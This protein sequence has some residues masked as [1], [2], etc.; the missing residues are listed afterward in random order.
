VFIFY[1][2]LA[3]SYHM[4]NYQ[5]NAL[6]FL[7]AS[8]L[9]LSIAN[10][11]PGFDEDKDSY[12]CFT[13]AGIFTFLLAL[14]EVAWWHCRRSAAIQPEAEVEATV[15]D[16]TAT[17]ASS[18]RQEMSMQNST[19]HQAVGTGPLFQNET[20]LED[21]PMN[22]E[23]TGPRLKRMPESKPAGPALVVSSELPISSAT[24]GAA[25]FSELPD[26]QA[27]RV[28][29]TNLGPAICIGGVEANCDSPTRGATPGS[30]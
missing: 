21:P 5:R 2:L 7:M 3:G 20:K 19:Q 27:L 23:P 25:T 26:P 18:P 29:T 15:F 13:A 1:A 24:A 9:F 16:A 14:G 8:G 10:A 11:I 6:R 28:Q 17:I 12:A 22:G 4:E 30:P